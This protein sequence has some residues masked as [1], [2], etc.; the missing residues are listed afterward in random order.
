MDELYLYAQAGVTV[1][2]E[3]PPFL[4]ELVGKADAFWWLLLIAGLVTIGVLIAGRQRGS[5]AAGAAF[6]GY[7]AAVAAAI[8]A[9]A[10]FFGI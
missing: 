3:A 9:G 6:F 5:Q 7:C 2:P 8:G 10:L 1:E 4:R